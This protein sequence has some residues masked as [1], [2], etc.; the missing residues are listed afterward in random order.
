MASARITLTCSYRW[1]PVEPDGQ[2]CLACGDRI[3]LFDAHTL[4]TT[5]Q[6]GNFKF[7]LNG[8]ICAS[9]FDQIEDKNTD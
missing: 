6:P 1:I 4:Q 3:Y 8:V 2:E 9:C 7:E 5:V